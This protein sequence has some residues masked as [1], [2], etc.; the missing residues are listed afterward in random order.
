MV[1]LWSRQGGRGSGVGAG[2]GH[3]TASPG[4]RYLAWPLAGGGPEVHA[5]QKQVTKERRNARAPAWSLAGGGPEVHA[6]VKSKCV[7][8]AQKNH[9]AGTPDQPELE[10]WGLQS[11]F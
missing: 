4:G 1:R 11:T 7:F 8:N 10:I 6:C 2:V 5:Y 9:E 3:Q